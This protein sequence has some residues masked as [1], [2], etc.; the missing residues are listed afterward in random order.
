MAVRTCVSCGEKKEKKTLRRFVWRDDKP[1]WDQEAV[2]IGR[3]VYCCD[4]E[5]CFDRLFTRQQKWKR[6]FRL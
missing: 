1:L 3:G 4:T 5:T 6:F 2:M